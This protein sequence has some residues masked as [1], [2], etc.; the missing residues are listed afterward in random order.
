MASPGDR[1][2]GLLLMM[3]W[4]SSRRRGPAS[5]WMTLSMQ[6]WDGWKHPRPR[7]FAALTTAVMFARVVMS[8]RHRAILVGCVL[9]KTML[10]GM[11]SARVRTLR[12][13]PAVRIWS[14]ASRFLRERPI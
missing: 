6:R 5:E 7:L 8:P 11:V 12:D 2:V 3:L 9:P 14:T 13:R 10:G 1:S 4:H